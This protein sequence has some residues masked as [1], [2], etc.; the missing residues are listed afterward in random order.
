MR[1]PR[2][3]EIARLEPLIIAHEQVLALQIA[4][5]GIPSVEV[6]ERASDVGRETDPETPR[7]GQGAVEDVLTQVAA[8]EELAD[9]QDALR[10]AGSGL[11]AFTV[12][13]IAVVLRGRRS[14]RSQAESEVLH[15]VR[16]PRLLHKSDLAGHVLLDVVLGTR[17][18]FLD[19][20]LFSLPCL[21][22]S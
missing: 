12:T 3:S 15:D 6:R 4:V 9:D 5:H 18:D 14:R 11:C 19:G 10:C 17:Q 8:W 20:N 21:R 2:Q 16:V 1:D 22:I 13:V 7:E